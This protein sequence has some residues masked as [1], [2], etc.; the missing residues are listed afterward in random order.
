M[1]EGYAGTSES[2]FRGEVEAEQTLQRGEWLFAMIENH[3][4]HDLRESSR[5]RGAKPARQTPT[6]HRLPR[7]R[8]H[9]PPAAGQTH[10]QRRP[11]HLLGHFVTCV[12]NPEKALCRRQL[13]GDDGQSIPDLSSCEPL[14][15]RNVALTAQNLTNIND[16]RMR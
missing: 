10:A 12:Y 13:T 2:G 15:C 5:P 8:D 3:E 14:R 7:Q 1:F 6:Q 4:H 16:R 9:R 11:T